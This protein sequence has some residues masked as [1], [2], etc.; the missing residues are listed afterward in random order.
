MVHGNVMIA[1]DMT[2]AFIDRVQPLVQVEFP[3][4]SDGITQFCANVIVA[5]PSAPDLTGE[6][7]TWFHA[8]DTKVL[9][10]DWIVG[11]AA[12]L[13]KG[14]LITAVVLTFLR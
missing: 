7:E 4:Q 2:F 10:L 3:L 12:H 5:E 14:D 11:A 1:S 6:T 9:P 8:R 13:R